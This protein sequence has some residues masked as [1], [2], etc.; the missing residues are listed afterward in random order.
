[1]TERQ[2]NRKNNSLTKEAD[3][4]IKSSQVKDVP[5]SKINIL[6]RIFCEKN[7]N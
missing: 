2:K 1:M 4:K 7:V 6:Y 5:K 3:D